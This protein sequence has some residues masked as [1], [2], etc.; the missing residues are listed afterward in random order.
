MAFGGNLQT[1]T[2]LT[3]NTCYLFQVQAVNGTGLSGPNTNAPIN[4]I[5]TAAP[6]VAP[7]TA[8]VLAF[9]AV[10]ATTATLTWA[11]GTGATSW[12]VTQVSPAAPAATVTINATNDGAALT[13]LW[14]GTAYSFVVNATNSGGTTSSNAV[15][16]TTI[17]AP[18]AAPTGL[19]RTA[20]R[21]NGFP[22][23]NVTW[24]TPAGSTAAQV[25]IQR[26]QGGGAWGP[27]QFV[28]SASG[29]QSFL[30]TAVQPGT[31]YTYQI[32][33]VSP[34]QTS[35][36]V[37]GTSVTTQGLPRAPNNTS[38]NGIRAGATDNVRVQW[39]ARDGSGVAANTVTLQYR[40]RTGTGN[41]AWGDYVTLTGLPGNVNSNVITGL[42]RN[43]GFQAQV[44]V[45]SPTGLQTGWSN[46]ASTTTP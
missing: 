1:V 35:A 15:S 17:A 27:S 46:V 7:P 2:G 24:T 38:A 3:A 12:T 30:D 37:V 21:T 22:S 26:R 40:V 25:E 6:P 4:Q 10:T 23:I 36:W 11:G 32:R 42:P 18:L 33:A 41:A 43:R 31:S 14:Q 19:G 9:S 29:A 16:F 20:L 28:A 13:G 39:T 44:R 5:C 34:G 45:V 8:P